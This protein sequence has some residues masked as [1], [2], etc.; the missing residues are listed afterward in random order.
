MIKKMC[1]IFKENGLN[2]TVECNLVITDFFY[3]TFDLKSG[4]YYPYRKQNNEILYIHKQS[5]HPPSII[6]QIPSM[7]SKRVSD[8]SCDSYHFN[9]TAP[10][11]NTA[12]KK[13]GFN[14]NIKYSPS[15]PK[16]RNRKRQII[17]FNPPYSV[18]VKTNVSKLFMRLIDKHFPRHHK[19]FNRN[20]VKLSY[21]CMP[22]MKNVI[23]KHNSKIMEDPKP[24][25]NKT[26]SCRQ[27]SDCPLNQNCLSECLVYNAVVNTSTT[28]NYYGTCEKRFKERYNNHTSS[29]RNKSRQKSTELS[30][31]IWELKENGENYKIYTLCII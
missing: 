6:K 18:N 14:E 31:Y 1:K 23:Q 24:T 12:I 15:Q 20:N 28:K 19:L 25:N 10:D 9:K 16:Q 30:N 4:T 29:F 22:S 7:I 2:I 27:K 5:N 13:S 17:W 26:C 21:S 11:Y 8:I 3:V